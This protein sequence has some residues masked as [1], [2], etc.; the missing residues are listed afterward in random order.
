M[1]VSSFS[2]DLNGSSA[3]VLRTSLAELSQIVVSVRNVNVGPNAGLVFVAANTDK[4]LD[5][6]ACVALLIT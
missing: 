5:G 3:G 2:P 1:P 4:E 6:R